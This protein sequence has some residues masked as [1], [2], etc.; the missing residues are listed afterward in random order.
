[1][2]ADDVAH[3]RVDRDGRPRLP[4][5]AADPRPRLSDRQAATSSGRST[6]TDTTPTSSS[7]AVYDIID[8]D[9]HS[10]SPPADRD[11]ASADHRRVVVGRRGVGTRTDVVGVHE[12][13]PLATHQR[14]TR[15]VEEAAE[16]L[17]STTR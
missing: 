8:T 4:L 9:C 14:V 6:S 15:P 12:V 5:P 11:V 7:R 3:T 13:A 10:P 17:T 16:R 1:M 2:T